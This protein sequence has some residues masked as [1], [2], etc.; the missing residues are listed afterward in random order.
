MN[1]MVL[2]DILLLYTYA[3]AIAAP[4]PLRYENPNSNV[5]LKLP[6]SLGRDLPPDPSFATISSVGL[7]R[8]YSY[9]YS[10]WEA[11]IYRTLMLASSIITYRLNAGDADR[12]VGP[13]QRYTVG[14]ALLSFDPPPSMTWLQLSFVHGFIL[15]LSREYAAATFLLTVSGGPTGVWTGSL[16]T[17]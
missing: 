9:A 2:I 6:L 8:C 11:D 14:H 16:T 10:E 12:R 5:T 7:V 1:F 4:P 3:T 15:A 13:E 17:D